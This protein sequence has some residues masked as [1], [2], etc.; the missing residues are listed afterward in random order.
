MNKNIVLKKK[1]LTYHRRFPAFNWSISQM[2]QTRH[3]VGRREENKN[4]QH[5]YSTAKHLKFVFFVFL[6]DSLLFL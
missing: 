2:S 6:Q 5:G 1:I 3:T 4:K